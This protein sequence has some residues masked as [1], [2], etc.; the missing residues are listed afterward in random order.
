MRPP[1]EWCPSPNFRKPLSPRPI[2]CIVVHATATASLTS[3]KAWLCNPASQVSAHYLLDLDGKIIRLVEEENIAW[4]AGYSEWKGKKNVNAFSIG[5]ELVNL[6]DGVMP[7]PKAQR[8]SLVQLCVPIAGDYHIALSDIV[9][10]VDIAS[11]KT[12]EEKAE[13]LKLHSDPRGFPWEDFRTNL[14]GAG[15]T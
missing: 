14:K 5:I 1:S 9:G 6:N 7:Y 12:P 4:H 15:L 3:P 10:H 13:H 2:T 11:G 8:D